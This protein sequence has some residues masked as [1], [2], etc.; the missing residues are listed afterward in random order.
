MMKWRLFYY[1]GLILLTSLAINAIANAETVI[2][3][4]RNIDVVLDI[5]QCAS[6]GSVLCGGSGS[7]GAAAVGNDSIVEAM[8]HVKLG[9]GSPVSGLAEGDFSL[10]GIQN[11]PPGVSPV[12]VQTAVCAACF[13]EQTAGVY[14]MA[15]RPS[16]GDW[17]DG[18]YMVVL[19]ITSGAVTRQVVVPIDVPN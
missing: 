15:I 17:G 14:R 1:S 6:A 10:I 18:T 16:S 5:D 13:A 7:V 2:V 11:P 8:I 3:P 4:S 12:F 9:N 19:E